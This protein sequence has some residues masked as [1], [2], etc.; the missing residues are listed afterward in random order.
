MPASRDGQ[1]SARSFVFF[2]SRAEYNTGGCMV[3]FV[4]ICVRNGMNTIL[5]NRTHQLERQ[6]TLLLDGYDNA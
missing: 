3:I 4:F 6:S 2:F 1:N 5:N